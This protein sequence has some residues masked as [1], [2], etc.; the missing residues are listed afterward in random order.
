MWLFVI[1]YWGLEVSSN[2]SLSVTMMYY[3]DVHNDNIDSNKCLKYHQTK[4][5]SALA[6]DKHRSNNIDEAL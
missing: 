6:I 3:N 4:Y 1:N 5:H 2:M